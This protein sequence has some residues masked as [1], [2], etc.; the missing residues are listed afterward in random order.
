MINTIVTQVHDFYAYMLMHPQVDFGCILNDTETTKQITMTNSS[1]LEV[2]YVW[3]FLKRPPARRVDPEQLDEG[4]DMQSEIET[5]SLE[6]EDD[7]EGGMENE[8]GA[9]G[10]SEGANTG[11]GSDVENE[12]KGERVANGGQSEDEAKADIQER[13]A[14]GSREKIEDSE[15]VADPGE[16][17]QCSNVLCTTEQPSQEATKT[18]QGIPP[19]VKRTKHKQ[20]SRALQGD[21][22]VPI[23]IEQVF[24]ILPL[25]GGL[26]PG[27]SE[28][29]QFT[30]HGH[31]GIAT[32]VTAVCRVEGGPAYQLRLMGE[33]SLVQ[34][35]ISTT[36]I[37]VGK[38]VII[39]G[40]TV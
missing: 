19:P 2:R 12:D 13:S 27:E 6:E 26:Q 34:Y 9:G 25:H 18:N 20:R 24:D 33:S 32:E 1:P 11:E 14:D 37:E 35:R 21:P 30:F 39:A 16:M 5:D 8:E 29:V 15:A 23:S 40:C 10:V 38:Q 7:D 22:F 3:S 31:T 28:T 17:Q 4:V 36:H